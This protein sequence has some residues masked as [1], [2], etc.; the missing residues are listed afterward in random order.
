MP[1]PARHRQIADDDVGAGIRLAQGAIEQRLEVFDMTHL[2]PAFFQDDAHQH[3]VD[4]IVLAEQ[5]AEPARRHSRLRNRKPEA[6]LIVVQRVALFHAAHAP[7]QHIDQRLFAKR[8]DEPGVEQV[9]RMGAALFRVD[10]QNLAQAQRSD[11][12]AIGKMGGNSAR[13]AMIGR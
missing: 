6:R 9:E 8:P 10:E 13:H 3:G 5:D 1:L 7:A 4:R 11:F 12:G 2:V